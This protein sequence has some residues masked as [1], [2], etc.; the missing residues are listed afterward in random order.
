MTPNHTRRHS[1]ALLT[2]AATLCLAAVASA[3]PPAPSPPASPQTPTPSSAPNSP[4]SPIARRKEEER[5][6][7]IGRA[8]AMLGEKEGS[9][10]RL[11]SLREEIAAT[12][13]QLAAANRTIAA[14]FTELTALRAHRTSAL[15]ATATAERNALEVKQTVASLGFP[16]ASLPDTSGG[17]ATEK[18]HAEFCGESDPAKKAD[19]FGKLAALRR[20]R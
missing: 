20:Q 15:A 2:I 14:Q 12:N 10:S 5:L 6:S 7:I 4:S 8:R 9:A 17:S 11:F 18:L 3:H 19:I 1:T 13:A 16:I